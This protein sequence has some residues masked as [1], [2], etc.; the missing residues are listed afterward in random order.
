MK[1]L[2]FFLDFFLHIDKNLSLLIQNFGMFSYLLLFLV[3]FMET[4]FVV[5]P[6]LPGDSL[7]FAA[8]ALAAKNDLNIYLLYFIL[9]LAAFLGDTVN[10]WV[11]HFI[12]P[13]A[14]NPDF[15][16]TIFNKKIKMGKI[17]KQE[18]LHRAEDFYKKHGGKAIVLARFV[19]IVRTFAPFVA[20]ISKMSYKHFIS[21]NFLGG[22]F[23]VTLF[24]FS[25]YF[26]GGIK[27][28]QNNFHYV[29]VA[30]ILIS[31]VPV[32]LEVIKKRA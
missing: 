24:L 26:F 12:G 30:I 8:G 11:G 22:F 17:F 5:T 13:K 16:F 31:F 2:N 9:I 28:V 3:I 21:Y 14:F 4:G 25:G 15:T 23:W 19:P 27:F 20:G 1:A 32:V 18:Y 7:L 10:Y 6:F 29:V